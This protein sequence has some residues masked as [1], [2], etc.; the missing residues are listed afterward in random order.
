M[1]ETEFED[2]FKPIIEPLTT[3]TKNI[4]MNVDK[5]KNNISV[6]EDIKENVKHRRKLQFQSPQAESFKNLSPKPILPTDNHASFRTPTNSFNR[7]TPFN[8]SKIS[9]SNRDK[10]YGPYFD[11]RTNSTKLGCSNF[12]I[13][14][15]HDFIIDNE[16]FTGTNGLYELIFQKTPRKDHYAEEDLNS[17][18]RIL[19]KTKAHLK[20][21]ESTSQVKGNR[22]YK[23]KH[24]IQPLLQHLTHKIGKAYSTYTNNPIDFVYWDNPNELVDRLRL[25]IAS[26]EAG[27]NNLQNEINSIV[28]ELRESNIIY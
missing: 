14:K 28:E 2:T 27:N 26:K 3:I 8:L 21:H 9:D 24:I 13:N 17:Y 20:N 16:I 5:N 10:T 22:G 7:S 11:V 18:H 15:Q 19:Q 23:Y 6:D 1:R 12:S 25:L 4:E